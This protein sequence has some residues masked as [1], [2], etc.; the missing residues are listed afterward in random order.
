M[1]TRTLL[2]ATAAVGLSVGLLAQHAAG[3]EGLLLHKAPLATEF[4]VD[5]QTFRNE[6]DAYV[7][8]L[9]EQMR[10]TLNRDLRR[11]L[12]PKL[13]LASGELRARG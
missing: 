13:V 9:N 1:V 6:I 2:T 5:T 10:E 12:T 4:K 8:E 7:R 11:E 3:A